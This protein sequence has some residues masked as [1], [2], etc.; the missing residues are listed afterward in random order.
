MPGVEK[1]LAELRQ[2]LQEEVQRR[3]EVEAEVL[4]ISELERL[5]FSMDL[6]DDICQRLAGISMFCKGLIH[7]VSPQSFLPELSELI[8]ETL[9]RTRRYAHD[10]FPM[11]LDTLGLKEALSALCD[12][13]AK[14]SACRCVFSWTGPD[15]SPFN[16]AQD[17]NIYRIAQEALQNAVKHA[18][19]SS[20]DVQ[21][22]SREQRTESREQN[23]CVIV[24]DNGCG[25]PR[26]CGENSG[27]GG[28]AARENKRGSGLGLHSMRYRAHQLGA[29]YS[30][31]S[32]KKNGTRMEIRIPLGLEN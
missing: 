4:R 15:K 10:S 28:S 6:H 9:A 23:F 16:S 5:R 24:Q 13:V 18:G 20:I 8:D 17:L 32:S 14:Q 30:L 12:K 11:E 7:S 31:K 22:E 2:K 3:T 29:E 27:S 25:D 1:E 26:L 21:V 19:A